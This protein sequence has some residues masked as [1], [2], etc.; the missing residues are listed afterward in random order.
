MVWPLSA[1]RSSVQ[2][3]QEQD[4]FFQVGLGRNARFANDEVSSFVVVLGSSCALRT[5]DMF[6]L[7]PAAFMLRT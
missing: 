5:P 6:V 1:N 7:L 2:A 4:H 3:G